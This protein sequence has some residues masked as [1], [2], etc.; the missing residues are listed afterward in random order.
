MKGLHVQTVDAQKLFPVISIIIISTKYIWFSFSTL[1][2]AFYLKM[3]TTTVH[4]T[5]VLIWYCLLLIPWVLADRI[6]PII[7]NYFAQSSCSSFI[8][9]SKNNNNS[10]PNEIKTLYD[11]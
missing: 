7:C 8:S 3:H 2:A 11:C 9:F 5:T 10:K 6:Q 1:I 4:T